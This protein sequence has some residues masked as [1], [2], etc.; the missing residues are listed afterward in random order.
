[1]SDYV[2]FDEP[3]GN[4]R[5]PQSATPQRSPLVQALINVGLAKD[6]RHAAIILIIVGIAAVVLAYLFW[7]SGSEPIYVPQ[8]GEPGFEQWAATHNG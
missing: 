4:Y 6:T 7:P 2:T 8:P 5:P 1:M 3:G